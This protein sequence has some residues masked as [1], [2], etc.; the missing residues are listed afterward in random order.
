MDKLHVME[1]LTNYGPEAFRVSK[2]IPTEK[3]RRLFYYSVRQNGRVFRRW[4]I[5]EQ[6]LKHDSGWI[7]E[8]I[9]GADVSIP[10]L[11]KLFIKKGFIEANPLPFNATSEGDQCPTTPAS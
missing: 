6:L 5:D 4:C 11:K 8:K 10:T 9:E 3:G 7:K 1:N 2:I